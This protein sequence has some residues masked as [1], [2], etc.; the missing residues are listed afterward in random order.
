MNYYEEECFNALFAQNVFTMWTL[1]ENSIPTA[2][3]NRL[4]EGLDGTVCGW[5][6][7]DWIDG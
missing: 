1:D 7:L 6:V 4:G 2:N 3:P 5:K